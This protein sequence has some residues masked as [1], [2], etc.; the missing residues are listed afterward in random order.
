MNPGGHREQVRFSFLLCLAAFAATPALA[1]VRVAVTPFEVDNPRLIPYADSARDDLENTIVNFGN[2]EIVERARMDEMVQETQLGQTS[3]LVDSSSA[4][5]F[6]HMLGARYLATGT[7]MKVDA[8][9]KTFQGYGV[10]TRTTIVTAALRVR[11][12]DVERGT[13]AYSN[14]VAGQAKTFATNSGGQ[15]NS[16]DAAKAIDDALAKLANDER[17]S[18]LFARIDGKQPAATNVDVEIAPVPDNCDI[19]ING[20]YQGSSPT[21]LALPEGGTVT[22]RLSKA[23]FQPWEKKVGVRSGMRIAPELE[24]P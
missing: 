10:S 20:V 15:V 1:Q 18:S 19:E 6:G 9:V 7:L 21:R 8:D 11:V 14:K 22:I 3:G 4:V 13:I 24:K 16:D 2:V 5:Q 23:G 17:F 12:Y